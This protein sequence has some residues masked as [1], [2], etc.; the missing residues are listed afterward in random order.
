MSIVSGCRASGAHIRVFKHNSAADLES[1]LR[2]AIVM[3]MPRSRRPWKKV[4]TVYNMLHQ[5]Q[6]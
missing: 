4:Y 5:Q 6:R 1:V 2:E 3:G